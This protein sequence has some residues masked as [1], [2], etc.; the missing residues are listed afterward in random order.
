MP[1]VDVIHELLATRVA[2]EKLGALGISIDEAQQLIDNRYVIVPTTGSTSSSPSGGSP[3]SATAW[4]S[5]PLATASPPTLTRSSPVDQPPREPPGPALSS[6][7][8]RRHGGSRSSGPCPR[9]S[10]GGRGRRPARPGTTA[11]SL[12]L[13]LGVELVDAL[14]GARQDRHRPR[15][16]PVPPR[17]PGCTQRKALPWGTAIPSTPAGG[18]SSG[19]R[20]RRRL[21]YRVDAPTEVHAGPRSMRLRWQTWRERRRLRRRIKAWETAHPGERWSTAALSSGP[22]RGFPRYYE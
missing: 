17:W 10:R 15:G 8:A 7:G 11:T 19:S 5:H 2:A 3:E 1:T 12:G 18:R 14:E 22:A 20:C 16:A 13:D 9:G 4:S 6:T 21:A